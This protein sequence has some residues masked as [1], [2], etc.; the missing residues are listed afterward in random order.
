MLLANI[1][2]NTSQVF[3]VHGLTIQNLRNGILDK[4]QIHSCQF[5]KYSTP[6]YLRIGYDVTFFFHPI[7][8]NECRLHM[9]NISQNNAKQFNHK[10]L[11]KKLNQ[12][13]QL[14]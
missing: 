2:I 14:Y 8:I 12:R 5:I 10:Q 1:N 13:L 9:R 4:L 11:Q 3:I 6:S 7:Y